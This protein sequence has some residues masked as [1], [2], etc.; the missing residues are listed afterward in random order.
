MNPRSGGR[1]PVVVTGSPSVLPRLGRSGGLV[2][3]AAFDRVAGPTLADERFEVWL[4][5]GA[6][7]ALVQRLRDAGIT[8]RSDQSVV[9]LTADLQEQGPGAVRRYQLIVFFLGV[10]IAAFALALAA[11]VDR[12]TRADEL[13]ALRRQGLDRRTVRTV[14]LLDYG[15]PLVI[16][17]AAGLAAGAAAAWLPLPAPA[18]FSDGWRVLDP[19]DGLSWPQFGLATAVVGAIMAATLVLIARRLTRSALRA[20]ARR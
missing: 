1:S 18:V 5:P 4:A 17:V 11:A 13:I 15:V 8:V 2:D 9:Q 16:A 7:D 14:V 10:L 6:D 19:P 20:E 12:R 3:L